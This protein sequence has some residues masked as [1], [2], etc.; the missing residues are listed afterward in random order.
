MS[1]K[2]LLKKGKML[3]YIP[4]SKIRQKSN[5]LVNNVTKRYFRLIT[6]IS[7]MIVLLKQSVNYLQRVLIKNTHLMIILVLK[8]FVY[9]IQKVLVQ[10]IHH[11]MKIVLPKK[12]VNYLRRVHCSRTKICV[13]I[14]P[15]IRTTK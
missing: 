13:K 10:S 5:A 15:M 7:I 6:L 1:T 4:T 3:T 11:L 14:M 9:Y 8:K 12:S 2:K